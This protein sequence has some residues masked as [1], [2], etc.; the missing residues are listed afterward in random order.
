MVSPVTVQVV[1]VVVVQVLAPGAE[2][3][4]YPVTGDPPSLVGAVQDTAACALPGTADTDTGADGAVGGGT[5]AVGVTA[6]E[7][8]EA[9]E[10]PTSLVAVVVKV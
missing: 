9:G 3:T 6:V 2:V 7:G 4:V 10:V 1:A 8:G 5:V